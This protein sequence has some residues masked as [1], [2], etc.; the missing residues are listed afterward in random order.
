MSVP[1]VNF[2]SHG[3]PVLYLFPSPCFYL[4]AKPHPFFTFF[5]A[6]RHL[7]FTCFS[8]I[9]YLFFTF[10]LGKARFPDWGGGGWKGKKK[11][12][13]KAEGDPLGGAGK[14]KKST[15]KNG[16]DLP[17]CAHVLPRCPV[18][19]VH[20]RVH[21]ITLQTFPHPGHAP[22]LEASLRQA[23]PSHLEASISLVN[24]NRWRR[25]FTY[26]LP[27]KH[28]SSKTF[29]RYLSFAFSLTGHLPSTFMLPSPEEGTFLLPFPRTFL[30]PCFHLFKYLC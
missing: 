30:L 20:A 12:S 11:V 6:F 22:P 2:W 18:R 21:V 16:G 17:A 8:P 23:A 5:L 3:P 13:E 24:P 25:C 4:W 19:R 1:F 26:L 27:S 29:C 9:F 10:S 14:V 15:K 7:V 28:L